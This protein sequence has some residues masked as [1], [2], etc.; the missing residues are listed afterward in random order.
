MDQGLSSSTPNEK[1]AWL[2]LRRL[3]IGVVELLERALAVAGVQAVRW[4][5]DQSLPEVTPDVLIAGLGPGERTLPSEVLQ[6]VNERH[7]HASVLLLSAESLM[8]PAVFLQEGFLAVVEPPFTPTVLAGRLKALTSSRAPASPQPFEV[9]ARRGWAGL[10]AGPGG[11]VEQVGWHVDASGAGSACVLSTRPPKALPQELLT[12]ALEAGREDEALAAEL[13]RVLGATGGWVGWE[14][15]GRGF[16]F[17]WPNPEWTLW[18]FSPSRVPSAHGLGGYARASAFGRFPAEPGD[19][20]LAT[21]GP[22]PEGLLTGGRPSPALS[23]SLA[24][25]GPA[26]LALLQQVFTGR[27]PQP[28]LVVE[29]W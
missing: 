21:P 29:V 9:S 28:C 8:R 24:G 14:G 4:E 11:A 18:L 26:T 25:G 1:H 10:W 27:P 17:Y 3:P 5:D 15:G 6:V 12:Q 22:L 16:R 13:A 19:V 20:L 2:A 7:P 23:E